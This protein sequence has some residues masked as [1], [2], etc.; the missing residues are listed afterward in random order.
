VVCQDLL[1]L[2]LACSLP[3]PAAAGA[4]FLL[5]ERRAMWRGAAEA[6]FCLDSCLC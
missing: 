3:L 4:R 6:V 5:A 2:R 1:W